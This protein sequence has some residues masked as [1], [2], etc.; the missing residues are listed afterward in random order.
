MVPAKTSCRAASAC[1]EAKPRPGTPLNSTER[2]RLKRVV[3]SVPWVG[4]MVTRV[5]SGIISPVDSLR[6]QISPMSSG[7]LLKSASAWTKTRNRRP[8]RLKSLT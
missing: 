5:E 6:T 3:I 1:P 7:V 4:V 2:C 8:K